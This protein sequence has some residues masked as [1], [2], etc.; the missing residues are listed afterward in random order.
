MEHYM[1]KRKKS[2]TEQHTLL[3]LGFFINMELLQEKF[4]ET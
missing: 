1:L 3:K 4:F 2:A